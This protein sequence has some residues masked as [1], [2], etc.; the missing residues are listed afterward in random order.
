MINYMPELWEVK[1]LLNL[2]PHL[3]RGL[4]ASLGI[5]YPRK[6]KSKAKQKRNSQRRLWFS[7]RF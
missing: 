6:K 7:N 1:L 2:T 4:A 5:P 3:H